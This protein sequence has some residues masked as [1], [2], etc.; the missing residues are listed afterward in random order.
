MPIC[1][2]CGTWNPDDK[3]VCWRCGT[4]LPKPQPKKR[5]KPIMLWGM[6]LW[7]WV[8]LALMTIVLLAGQCGLM[9]TM[10]H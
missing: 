1:P 4:P 10:P 8:V 6:P 3:R 9:Q 5:R 7:T 2:N